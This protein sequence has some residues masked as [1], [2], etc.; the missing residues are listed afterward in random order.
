[1]KMAVL[2]GIPITQMYTILCVI[3]GFSIMVLKNQN[4]LEEMC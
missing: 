3:F 2:Y 1:M 4:L